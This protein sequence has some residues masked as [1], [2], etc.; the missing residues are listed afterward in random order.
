MT[1]HTLTSTPRGRGRRPLFRTALTTLAAATALAASVPAASA[2]LDPAATVAIAGEL[3]A[4]RSYT[5]AELQGLPQVS[6]S[7][8]VGGDERQ[9]TG[10]SVDALVGTAT[11]ILPAGHNPSL[12]VTIEATGTGGRTVTLAHAELMS[13][14]GNRTAILA[15]QRDGV[16]L[17][18]GPQLVVGGDSGSAR[19]LGHVT[20]LG[21]AVQSA[22]MV[23]PPSPGALTIQ[24]PRDSRVLDAAA[25]AALPQETL[26]VSYLSGN[27]AVPQYRNEVGPMLDTV[28]RAA[29]FVPEHVAWVSAVAPDDYAAVVTPGEMTVGGKLLQL[30]LVENGSPLSQPRL[31]VSGDVRGG[32]YSSNTTGL[33]VGCVRYVAC[34]IAPTGPAGP[35]GSDGVAGSDGAPGAAGPLGPAGPVGPAGATGATGAVGPRGATGPRGKDA[36]VTCR[37]RTVRGK[38]SQ[39]TCTVKTTAKASALRARL[40]RNGRTVATGRRTGTLRAGTHRITLSAQGG[41]RALRRSDYR[42]VLTQ[43]T[44]SRTATSTRGATVR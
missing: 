41:A 2:A 19:V 37:V 22:Q 24:G 43:R 5:V 11:P 4:P 7:A 20:R 44:G 18:S 1:I 34:D 17:T 10:V 14:F 27:P 25:L 23:A 40:V 26:D 31:I 6:V 21:V 36:T 28:L 33:V 42:L 8:E 15:L 38:R 12:R 30:A 3:Q 13:G 39:V 29:G 35:A 9:F 16:D 32:R